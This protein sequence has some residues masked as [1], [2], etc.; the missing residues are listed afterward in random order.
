MIEW[1]TEHKKRIVFE[2]EEFFGFL[3]VRVENGV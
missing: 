2:N 1:E 3:S